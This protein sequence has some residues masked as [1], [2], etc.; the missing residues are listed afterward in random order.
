MLDRPINGCLLYIL[1]LAEVLTARAVR[2]LLEG[3]PFTATERSAITEMKAAAS[4]ISRQLSRRL[5][6]PS[7]VARIL[8]SLSDETL[9]F[10]LAKNKSAVVKRQVAACLTTY[11]TMKPV[12]T[13]KELKAFHIQPGPLYGKIL[14]RL[15]EARLDG[16]VT[17]EAEERDLVQRMVRQHRT[18]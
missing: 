2:E 15:T 10:V 5:R 4:D 9:I 14:T 6:R 17:S 8:A 3:F 12:L 13:G 11:R 7:E 1:V 16:E 18:G